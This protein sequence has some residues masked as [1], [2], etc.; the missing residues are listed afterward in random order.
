MVIWLY[1]P[2]FC[3]I[4]FVAGHIS[5]VILYI[6]LSVAWHVI[7]VLLLGLTL[8]GFTSRIDLTYVLHDL[9]CD[10]AYTPLL[11]VSPCLSLA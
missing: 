9:F 8:L 6:R 1:L 5:L 3:M 11:W 4:Y 7:L 2:R 10:R